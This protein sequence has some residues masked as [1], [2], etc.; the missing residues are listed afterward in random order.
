MMSHSLRR[1]EALPVM[2]KAE[3]FRALKRWSA[4]LAQFLSLQ[5]LVQALG[6][7]AGILLVRTLNQTQYA[8]YTMANTMQSALV[9]LADAGVG[10]ALSATGG[11]VW[12]DR[13]RFGEL[14]QTG[15]HVRKGL[16]WISGLIVVPML[17]WML[18][19]HGCGVASAACLVSLVLLGASLR[20]TNDV[21]AVVPRLHGQIGR[22]QKSDLLG[23]LLRLTLI[24][25]S[26]VTFV[27]AVM[28]VLSASLAMRLQ[29][30]FLK[31]WAA[32]GADLG[33]PPNPTDKKAL[34][35]AVKHQ[36]P[37]TIYYCFQGQ[38]IILMIS[39]YGKTRNVAE[40]G[41]LT[42][43]G[44]FFALTTSVMTSIVLPRFARCRSGARLKAMYGQIMA[45]YALLS[46]T[47]AALVLRMPQAFLWLLGGRYAYLQPDLGCLV[48]HEI[49]LLFVGMIWSLNAARGWT[50]HTWT[51][52]PIIIMGQ[53]ALIP[54]L[55]MST[56][57]GVLL[58]NCLPFLPGLIPHLYQTYKGFQ[59]TP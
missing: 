3:R 4:L 33:C 42:R 14:I 13:R 17:G 9:L 44:L 51:S 21:F 2:A 35:D 25:V 27:D 50:T 30:H 12:Q 1:R 23:G 57:K 31:R 6:L 8:F 54:V 58:L 24:V 49:I 46:V 38:I 36:A 52:V 39:I 10:S 34:L 28:G 55:D 40:L 22:L 29:G 53:A 20:L 16:A 45:T 32:D 43:L 37:S 56:I 18:I 26:C 59:R 41:A 15:L 19:S 7:V 48:L 11:A 5:I 47:L